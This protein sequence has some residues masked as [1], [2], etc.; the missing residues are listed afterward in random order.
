MSR[1]DKNA[2]DEDLT[3]MTFH[4]DLEIFRK[5]LPSVSE[6]P[7][8]PTQQDLFDEIIKIRWKE[9]QKAIEWTGGVRKS[10]PEVRRK[11]ALVMKKALQGTILKDLTVLAAPPGAFKKP[12][13]VTVDQIINSTT[14]RDI[15]I[16]VNKLG[17]ARFFYLYLNTVSS[18]MHKTI[19]Y[20]LRF[21]ATQDASDCVFCGDPHAWV[22]GCP[23]CDHVIK[24]VAQSQVAA[25]EGL[26]NQV[27]E[28]LKKAKGDNVS[29][30][31]GCL[32]LRQS[33]LSKIQSLLSQGR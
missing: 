28:E 30:F 18:E 23:T 32:T 15:L 19:E 2:K 25:L 26:Y 29:L 3:P 24:R 21:P 7:D 13:L 4:D 20:E 10:P 11:A 5:C 9:V 31:P 22:S 16:A 27:T 33:H 17:F 12:V 1:A 14:F 8:Q 6:V